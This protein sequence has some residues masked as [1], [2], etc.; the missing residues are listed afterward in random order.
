VEELLA[1]CEEAE[2]RFQQRRREMDEETA[3][4][5]GRLEADFRR[6]LELER[7]D[8]LSPFLEVLDNLERTIASA[9]TTRNIENLLAGVEM[10]ASLFRARLKSAGVEPVAVLDRPFDPNSSQAVGLVEVPDPERDGVV[11]E[12]VVRGYR[13]GDQLLRPA[14]VRVG[15]LAGTG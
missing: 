7:R 4:V 11:V 3:R 13:M 6:R 15:K 8:L 14:Q 10:T 2:R 5:R 9:G 1:R 12:E